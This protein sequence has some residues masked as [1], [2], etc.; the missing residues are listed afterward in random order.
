MG[1]PLRTTA[2]LAIDRGPGAMPIPGMPRLLQPPGNRI[3]ALML[4]LWP[5]MIGPDP[6]PG[7]IGDDLAEVPVTSPKTAGREAKGGTKLKLFATGQ[8]APIDREAFILSFKRQAP[9]AALPCLTATKP[10]P[11]SVHVTATLLKSGKLKNVRP[12]GVDAVF[13]DC[14]VAAV[15]SMDFAP[16]AQSLTQESQ[17]LMWRID[18]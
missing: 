10:S 6:D 8:G 9:L 13:P 5:L 18:W 16:V 15:E 3:I 4:V 7:P 12:V 11:A 14:L 2:G 1:D 17:Q